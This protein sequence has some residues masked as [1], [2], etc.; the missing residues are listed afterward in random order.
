MVRVGI[1]VLCLIWGSLQFFP[2]EYDVSCEFI[3]YDLYFAELRS[4]SAQ[5]I[6]SFY[7]K[8]MLNLVRCSVWIH[9]DDHMIF[10]FHFINGMYHM[11]GFVDVDVGCSR[12]PGIIPLDHGI[13]P[14]SCIW[15]AN[16]LRIFASVFIRECYWLVVFS[17]FV[18]RV[19]PASYSELVRMLPSSSVLG[20]SLHR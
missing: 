20:K 8:R 15:F 9:W 10:I 3:I 2:V 1:L 11:D 14:F 4:F 12:I 17:D 6:E 13:W 5:F 16:L 7:H 19:M 18:I